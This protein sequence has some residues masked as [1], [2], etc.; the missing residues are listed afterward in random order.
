LTIGARTGT[1]PGMLSSR[2]FNVIVV[3]ADAPAGYQ[4]PTAAG[5]AITYHGTAVSARF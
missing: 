3:S 1:F 2:A 5:R 4:G